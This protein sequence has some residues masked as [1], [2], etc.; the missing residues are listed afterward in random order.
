MNTHIKYPRAK[1]YFSQ[2]SKNKAVSYFREILDSGNLIQGK[3]VKEFEDKFAKLIGVKYAVATNSCTS[4]L[5]IVLKSLGLKGKTVLVPSQTFVATGNAVITSGNYPVFVDMDENSMSM[6]LASI[7]KNMTS[8]VAAIILVHIGGM[9]TPEYHKIKQ[10]C[11]DRGVYLLEDS[12]HAIGSNIDG[13][14]AGTLGVAGCFS[15]YPT[16]IMTTGEGG[17]ITTDSKELADLCRVYR[18]HGGDGKNFYYSASNDRMTEMSA[19][20]GLTQIEEVKYFINDRNRIASSYYSH[21]MGV[22]G[23]RLLPVYDNIFNCY[24]NFYFVLSDDIDRD[25]FKERLLNFG[26]QT[27][28]AYSPPCHKQKV[29]ESYI[30]PDQDFSVT[31]RI[32]Q[33]HISLPM[34]VG[35]SEQ[36]ITYI[37]SKVKECLINE[38]SNTPA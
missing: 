21:L 34:Y 38:N 33:K 36:D 17:M 15:F 37:I 14:G 26:I 25:K 22:A 3:Y 27:G 35:L 1:P 7:K 5:E 13:L 20:I 31:E 4:S 9:I 19:A 6:S 8:E 18:S 24:W 2:K 28:D 11:D 12:A 23:V 16:K 32:L 30:K 29:F 10:Y